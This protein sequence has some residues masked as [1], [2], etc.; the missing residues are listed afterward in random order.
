MVGKNLVSALDHNRYE[1]LTPTSLDV[2]LSDKRSAFNYI[3]KQRP[4]IVV[5]AAGI[6]GGIQANLAEPI[7]F[8]TKNLEIGANTI[9]ASLNAG[10]ASLINLSSSCVYPKDIGSNLTEDDILSGKLEPTNEGYA[11][12]KITAM[13]LCDFVRR[14]HPELN[15]KSVE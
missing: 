11:L 12:A 2:D 1:V 8:L 3:D 6:V 5:H 15:Y 14:E 4:G 10:V 9:L 13:R 7:R